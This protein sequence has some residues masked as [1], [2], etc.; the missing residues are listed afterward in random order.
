VKAE[1]TA[2]SLLR[3]S[4][5]ETL[6]V[7]GDDGRSALFRIRDAV[8]EQDQQSVQTKQDVDKLLRERGSTWVW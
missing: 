5:G 7:V 4:A 8:K 1:M 6:G 3:K 2:E